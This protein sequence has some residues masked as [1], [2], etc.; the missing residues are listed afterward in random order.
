[1]AL[2]IEL[3]ISLVD[4]AELQSYTPTLEYWFLRDLLSTAPTSTPEGL[5]ERPKFVVLR[6]G[7]ENS[8][9]SPIK[10]GFNN[11]KYQAEWLNLEVRDDTGA[12]IPS[13]VRVRIRPKAGAIAAMT[14]PA[15]GKVFYDLVG[16]VI[17]GWLVF[18]GA[19]YKLPPNGRLHVQFNYGGC[20]SNILDLQFP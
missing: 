17:E 6:I 1:M 2:M 19:K 4:D 15:K 10:T 13:V 11:I 3:T 9:E 18:T 5:V 14:V 12:T 7:F 16:E 8:T 20:L